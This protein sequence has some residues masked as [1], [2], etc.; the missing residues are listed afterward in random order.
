M[1]EGVEHISI[2]QFMKEVYDSIPENF[3]H[4]AVP[5]VYPLLRTIQLVK[6]ANK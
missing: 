2:K 4:Q 6:W 1:P 5:E 3:T